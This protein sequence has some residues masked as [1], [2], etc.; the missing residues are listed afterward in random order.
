M[1]CSARLWLVY[2]GVGNS[3]SC[4]SLKRVEYLKHLT[5]T[6]LIRFAA[7]QASGR[8]LI[9]CEARVFSG[10]VSSVPK[11]QLAAQLISPVYRTY[12][13]ASERKKLL[14]SYAQDLQCRN[15]IWLRLR[16]FSTNLDCLLVIP[17]LLHTKYRRRMFLM[18]RSWKEHRSRLAVFDC[19][20]KTYPL[21][22]SSQR[23]LC[24]SVSSLHLNARY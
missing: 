16:M 11:L 8:P 12:C 3:H 4:P 1:A 7:V 18:R 9:Q 17:L 22:H 21:S 14:K 23:R 19:S 15:H 24:R 20:T 5:S 13:C 10:L 2:I 6:S